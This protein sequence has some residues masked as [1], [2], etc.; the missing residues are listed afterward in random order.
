MK[1]KDEPRRSESRSWEKRIQ[2][3]SPDAADFVFKLLTFITDNR[4]GEH[5]HKHE[6]AHSEGWCSCKQAGPTNGVDHQAEDG[7][8]PC[9]IS[10]QSWATDVLRYWCHCGPCGGRWGSYN[11]VNAWATPYLHQRSQSSAALPQLQ[12]LP[13]LF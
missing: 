2:E 4:E 3:R 12:T 8:L 5:A 6:D 1:K 11:L 7:C 9:L 13:L 10:G